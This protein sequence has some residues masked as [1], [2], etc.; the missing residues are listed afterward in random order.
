MIPSLVMIRSERSQIADHKVCG[1]YPLE[2]NI[3]LLWHS[4]V[5]EIIL[6]LNESDRAVY[7]RMKRRVEKLNGVRVSLRSGRAAAIKKT[8]LILSATYFIQFHH[9]IRFDDFFRKK[10]NEY[11]IT[12]GEDHFFLTSKDDIV[13][14]EKIAM[15]N[16]RMSA[17]GAVARVINK[18]ISLPISIRLARLGIHPNVI[19]FTT[20]L[21]MLC[22]SWMLWKNEYWWLLASATIFQLISILDGC[23]GE[24]AKLTC[25]FSRAGAIFDTLNDY[26]CLILYMAGSSYVYYLKVGSLIAIGTAAVAFG[27][28]FVMMGAIVVYLKRYSLSKSFGAYNREFMA[29]LPLND[30]FAWVA[31]RLQYFTRKEFYSWI[32]FFLAIPGFLYLMIPY[33]ALSVLIGAVLCVLLNFR[34][35]PMMP[36]VKSR[37]DMTYISHRS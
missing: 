5:K 23:D 27:G 18:R 31:V 35:F 9:L 29:K 22:G 15:E 34:Y 17:G 26:T 2:R 6:D 25:K 21:M 37:V 8:H 16:I 19:T 36:R 28:L 7:E 30:P 24:V 33:T 20:F 12:N 3:R 1:L 10:G 4:G 13:R 11:R 14:A 32:V